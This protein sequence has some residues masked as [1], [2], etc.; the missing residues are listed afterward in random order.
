MRAL[1]PIAIALGICGCDGGDSKGA[2]G[3]PFA[4]G[5]VAGK[6]FAYVGSF[7]IESTGH[8]LSH[9]LAAITVRDGAVGA[10]GHATLKLQ[11]TVSE[12]NRTVWF[13]DTVPPRPLLH[14]GGF[15]SLASGEWMPVRERFGFLDDGQGFI[16]E[17]KSVGNDGRAGYQI[18][19]GEVQTVSLPSPVFDVRFGARRRPL[20]AYHQDVEGVVLGQTY[21]DRTE[22]KTTFATEPGK[23]LT[24]AVSGD[25]AWIATTRERASG[26]GTIFLHADAAGT[27]TLVAEDDT[28]GDIVPDTTHLEVAAG[29]V[30][31]QPS[32]GK[33]VFRVEPGKVTK[34]PVPETDQLRIAVGDDG[35]LFMG[36]SDPTVG[37]RGSVAKLQGDE[38]VIIGERGMS[39]HADVPVPFPVGPDL[40]VGIRTFDAEDVPRGVVIVC[41]GPSC[42]PARPAGA[43]TDHH[44]N[45]GSCQLPDTRSCKDIARSSFDGVDNF[46]RFC[47]KQNGSFTVAPCTH[48]DSVGACMSK[49]DD[50]DNYTWFYAADKATVD[51]TKMVCDAA[52]QQY[53]AP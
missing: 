15:G 13:T 35:T 5:Y 8:P 46:T 6:G 49:S 10:I 34:V 52:K 53:V 23:S 21:L 24:L 16:F 45:V 2:T 28:I 41:A 36:F 42:V 29:R 43:A 38:L 37:G 3:D 47:T 11:D 25:E 7:G 4:G 17:M 50:G 44:D 30:Y 12:S 39:Q 9:D 48:E 33:D 32:G 19:A 18:G 40:Y 14:G 51:G 22:R 26:V 1:G 27:M 20:Y 31:Y